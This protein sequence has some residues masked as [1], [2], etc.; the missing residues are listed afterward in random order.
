RAVRRPNR[1]VPPHRTQTL[2]EPTVP[3][4]R[5]ADHHDIEHG[6]DASGSERLRGSAE[7]AAVEGVR[8][9]CGERTSAAPVKVGLAE[10]EESGQYQDLAEARKLINALAGLVTAAAPEIGNEHARSLRDGL[11]SLQLAFAESLPFPDAPGEA[12]GEKYTGRVS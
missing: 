8:S 9:A 11:R 12:P 7:V 3:D 1:A 6:A 2:E 4:H 5:H 10:D